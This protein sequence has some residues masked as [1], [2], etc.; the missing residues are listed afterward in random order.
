MFERFVKRP[1]HLTR[2]SNGP[3]AEERSQFLT[4]LVQEGQGWGRLRVIN[5]LLLEVSQ[6]VD[7]N[8][9]RSYTTCDSLLRGH[10]RPHSDNALFIGSCPMVGGH[11]RV[12]S[13]ISCGAAGLGTEDRREEIQ[14]GRP[15]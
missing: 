14:S 5:C 4:H 1:F 2:Y 6:H 11:K 13:P 3:Y 12:T 7:L 9:Q 8:G 15:I 10:D